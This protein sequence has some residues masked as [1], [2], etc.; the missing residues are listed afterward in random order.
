MAHRTFEKSFKYFA[1][2]LKLYS[3]EK[4]EIFLISSQIYTSSL[5][6]SKLGKRNRRKLNLPNQASK[7]ISTKV[8]ATKINTVAAKINWIYSWKNSSSEFPHILQVFFKLYFHQNVSSGN[9]ETHQTHEKQSLPQNH[10]N[11]QI[12]SKKN[13]LRQQ[14]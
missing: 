12:L 3:T 14:N 4:L 6:S 11:F 9:R 7:A 5:I 8:T 10:K 13:Q 2:K 1:D